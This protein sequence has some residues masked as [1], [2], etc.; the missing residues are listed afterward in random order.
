[1]TISRDP[2]FNLTRLLAARK[3]ERAIRRC[4]GL[5]ALVVILGACSGGSTWTVVPQAGDA[6]SFRGGFGSNTGHRAP[7]TV[8][9]VSQPY[10]VERRIT[11]KRVEVIMPAEGL[12][13][14]TTRIAFIGRQVPNPRQPAG[15]GYPGVICTDTWPPHDFGPTYDSTDL[16]LEP[17]D[18]FAPTAYL[19]ILKTGDWTVSAFVFTYEEGGRTF[20]Q[21]ISNIE[22]IIQG[23]KKGDPCP[24]GFIWFGQTSP[25][26]RK[27][28]SKK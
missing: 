18:F 10:D 21:T 11:L 16:V 20:T 19:R 14:L 5:L 8:V 23:R 6:I 17:R 26:P 4:L 15:G 22:F 12:E 28:T 24:V 9:A 2:G 1:M 25:T 27:S 7:G 13:L 3:V